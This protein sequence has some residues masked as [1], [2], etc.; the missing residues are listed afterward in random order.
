VDYATAC[1]VVLAQPDYPYSAATKA[2]TLDIPIYGPSSGNRQY[3]HPQ[4][5][6]M[7]TLP[8]MKGAQVV[9][10]RMWA[11]CGDYIG[12][13][14]GTGRTVTQACQRAYKVLSEI[15]IPDMIYRD[16]IGEK[17][18]EELP[19]LQAHGFAEEFTYG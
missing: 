14:T 12:V 11:T 15:Q 4:S 17:L 8:A 13:V 7:A 5:V 18:E 1:G 6:K 10:K 19:R 16:D 3:F 2:Q 9:D